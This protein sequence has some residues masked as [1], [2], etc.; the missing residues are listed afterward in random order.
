MRKQQSFG[1]IFRQDVRYA[2]RALSVGVSLALAALSNSAY[3]SCQYEIQSD[4][5][6]GSIVNMTVTNDTANTAN[7]W[8]VGW[9]YT[10]SARIASIWNAS[11]SGTNPYV[12]TNM[13]YNGNLQPGQSASFGFQVNGAANVPVLT[14]SLCN[15]SDNT[16]GDTGGSTDDSTGGTDTGGSTG[17]DTGGNTGGDTGTNTEGNQAVFRVDEAG[18]ITKRWYC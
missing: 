13:P 10:G 18:H 5:G 9:E 3:A 1:N 6:A 17:G 15:P 11:L 7:A 12:I 2:K 4:W 16:D 14:G 8:N